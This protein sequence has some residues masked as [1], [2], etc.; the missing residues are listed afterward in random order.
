[1][2]SFNLIIGAFFVAHITYG[3][4]VE[5]RNKQEITRVFGQYVPKELVKDLSDNPN[6]LGLEGESRD[7]TVLF[8]DVRSF[9]TISEKLDPRQLKELMN[10]YL[11]PVTAIIY[12]NRGTVDKYIGDAVMAF[13]GAP[14]TSKR[15]AQD[16]VASGLSML[17]EA[18]KMRADF[19]ARGWPELYIG[20]G[21]NTGSM[22]VGNM[23]SE[24]RVAYTVLGDAVNLGARLEGLTKFYGV[25]MIVSEFTRQEAPAFV[26][27][28]L[29][30]VRVKGKGLPVTIYEPLGLQGEVPQQQMTFLQ[31]YDSALAAYRQRRWD[32][33]QQ[34]LES[35]M[36]DDRKHRLYELYLERTTHYRENP[37][38]EDW[39]SVF[40]LSFK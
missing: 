6:D 11:T 39:D 31:R 20:I 17:Q 24:Y 30:K 5:R 9:T 21:I 22:N 28:E 15:H 19:K 7:M 10:A 25:E 33:A 32:E 26:Y 35:L 1:M 40:T 8:S 23:G 13:W 37:P 34:I 3:Y 2:A 12:R 14:L 18:A 16:A 36:S 4:F 27:R 38:G 29:D